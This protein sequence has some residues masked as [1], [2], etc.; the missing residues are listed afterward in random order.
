MA[1]DF[2]TKA[3]ILA[4]AL[5]GA[6]CDG[7]Q[8][9]NPPAA[10]APEVPGVDQAIKN[11]MEIFNILFGQIKNPQQFEGTA[12]QQAVYAARHKAELHVQFIALA[13]DYK[14]LPEVG[15]RQ[16]QAYL[17][18]ELAW[19]KG[20]ERALAELQAI[21]T[22]FTAE[23]EQSPT[24]N[25]IASIKRVAATD[26]SNVVN[27]DRRG[28]ERPD[29]IAAEARTLK[30]QYEK[31]SPDDKAIVD[32]A[33][34]AQREAWKDNA[35]LS[36]SLRSVATKVQPEK[37]VEKPIAKIAPQPKIVDNA[38]SILSE[39]LGVAVR[40]GN[41]NIGAKTGSEQEKARQDSIQKDLN[42][43]K[44]R[45]SD[46]PSGIKAQVDAKIAEKISNPDTN[47][48]IKVGYEAI[49]ASFQTTKQASPG[50]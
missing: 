24:A 9:T 46:L 34:D 45:Y 44:D 40:I 17:T 6:A 42:A 39:A 8:P 32:N 14:K 1:N 37:P 38:D 49:K 16:V 43:L 27:F 2:G 3:A 35:Y 29:I 50:R 36:S 23:A 47:P 15:K 48:D 33:I 5:T 21:Q 19:V 12:D 26:A 4:T 31:L 18:D 28:G 22:L 11:F 30:G 13:H 10:S 25:L 7:T 41:D 20:D